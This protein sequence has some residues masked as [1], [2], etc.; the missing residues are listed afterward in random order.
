MKNVVNTIM[1]LE[2][3]K[4]LNDNDIEYSIHG[5]GGCTSCGLEVR[6]EG[7]ECSID[8]I[9]DVINNYLNDYWIYV[10]LNEL[11]YLTIHSKYGGNDD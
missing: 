3:N 4:L 8:R 11:G 2:I 1:I 5:I 10:K 7:K 9:I 6:Q